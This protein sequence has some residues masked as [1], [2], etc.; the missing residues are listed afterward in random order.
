MPVHPPDHGLTPK[1]YLKRERQAA[2]KSEYYRGE[3]FAMSG[4][5]RNH[6]MLCGNVYTALR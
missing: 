4:G 6:A 1:Q 3:T 5:S 2:F